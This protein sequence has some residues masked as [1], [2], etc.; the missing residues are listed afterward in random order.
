MLLLQHSVNPPI[1]TGG[2]E[3]FKFAFIRELG[4]FQNN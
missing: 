1:L 3:E 2:L 4:N